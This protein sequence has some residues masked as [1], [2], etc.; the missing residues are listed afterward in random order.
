MTDEQFLLLIF[1]ILYLGECLEWLPRWY[2]GFSTV[3]G[4]AW[5]VRRPSREFGNDS[6]GFLWKF[7]LPPL[8]RFV[9]TQPL[10]FLLTREGVVSCVLHSPNPGRKP[11][12]NESFASWRDLESLRRDGKRLLIGGQPFV[13]VCSEREA[14]HLEAFLGEIAATPPGEREASVRRRIGKAFRVESARRRLNRFRRASRPLRF[15]CNL[16]FV[17]L[18][19]GIPP[20]VWRWGF[21]RTWLPLLGALFA[22]ML[23][24][25]VAFHAVHRRFFPRGRAER[26]TNAILAC[27]AP[28]HAIRLGDVAARGILS[29]FHPLACARL[30]LGAA[31]FRDFARRWV[32][33]L[34]FPIPDGD[35]EFAEE[36]ARMRSWWT[37]DTLAFLGRYG[38][39]ERSLLE[40]PTTAE[41]PATASYCPRCHSTYER[42]E[43]MCEDCGGMKTTP[44]RKGPAG[45]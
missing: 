16:L 45:G 19:V 37:A 32:R 20:V 10:P 17:Y 2:V 9:A 42:S 22:L 15:L 44:C 3:A 13:K 11:R 39:D 38:L 40:P 18:F 12:P 6:A 27:I 25:A 34:T 26:W 21:E 5:R 35:S 33:D 1:G 43:A 36:K 7:P 30:L 24:S 14:T 28:Q 41:N 23:L 8:G 31:D 29:D 4:R